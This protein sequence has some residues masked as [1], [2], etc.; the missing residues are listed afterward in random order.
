MAPNRWHRSRENFTHFFCRRGAHAPAA[1]TAQKPRVCGKGDKSSFR[2]G[3]I[4]SGPSGGPRFRLTRI[5][6][7]GNLII[8]HGRA[9]A[10]TRPSL[11]PSAPHGGQTTPQSGVPK[12][13]SDICW[14]SGGHIEALLGPSWD[15]LG[16]IL[17][18]FGGHPGAL[19]G[20]SL[21][22]LG[23]SRRIQHAGPV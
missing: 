9:R 23:L 3:N 20:R 10:W 5:L 1:T 8:Y 4:H 19:L 12:Q 16:S 21:G 14:L 2:I 17:G 15:S 18:L 6:F 13:I 22:S 7:H 11:T